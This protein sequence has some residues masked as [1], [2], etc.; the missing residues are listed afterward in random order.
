[1]TVFCMAFVIFE[2][3]MIYWFAQGV[4]DESINVGTC[5]GLS[6]WY[7]ADVK[8]LKMLQLMMI[9]SSRRLALRVGPFYDMELDVFLK[10]CKM[11]YTV[12][13]VF[14]RNL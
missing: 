2:L 4:V 10:I 6:N 9:R 1:M 11:M 14:K 12:V 8:T 7:E 13:T 3:F 5:I